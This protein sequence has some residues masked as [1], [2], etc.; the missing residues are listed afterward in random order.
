MVSGTATEAPTRRDFLFVTTGAM[1]AVAAGFAVWPLIDQM[2]PDA[3]VRAASDIMEIDLRSP[4]QY[5]FVLHG[6]EKKD[7][8]RG[9][10]EA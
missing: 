8:Q 7:V 4:T 5:F 6:G 2:N 1:G 3:R 9:G 10:K